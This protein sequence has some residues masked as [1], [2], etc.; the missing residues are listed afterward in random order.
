MSIDLLKGHLIF[1][2][3]IWEF[4]WNKF[5]KK[6]NL[7]HSPG[8]VLKKKQ[9]C[10]KWHAGD[11]HASSKLLLCLHI[12]IYLLY[13]SEKILG[14]QSDQVSNI[15]MLLPFSFISHRRQ[16]TLLCINNFFK[17]VFNKIVSF[18]KIYNISFI[19][20]IIYIFYI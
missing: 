18:K 17:P 1:I 4:F 14:T 6:L 3:K 15:G 7:T 9:K 16:V 13:E 19:I 5:L 12:H 20:Y 10:L 2:K 11:F 8:V